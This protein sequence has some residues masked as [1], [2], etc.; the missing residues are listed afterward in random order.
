MSI[1]TNKYAQVD[2]KKIIVNREDRQRKLIDVED[3]VPSI[4]ERGVLIPIIINDDF[5]LIAGERR[6]TATLQLGL[7]TIPVRFAKDL[8][9]RDRQIIELE[10]N[11][12][13]QNLTWQ[14]T[15]EAVAK[16]HNLLVSEASDK[17]EPISW[18]MEQTAD[19]VGISRPSVSRYVKLQSD[20]EDGVPGV[21]KATKI[22]EAETASKRF[23]SRQVESA[24]SQIFSTP[25]ATKTEDKP[26]VQSNFSIQHADVIQWLDSYSGPQFNFI[27]MDLPYGVKLSSQ[28]G[29]QTHAETYDGDAPFE[30]LLDALALHWN[31]IAAPECHVMFWFSMKHYQK[32]LDWLT[33]LGL[34][35]DYNPGIWGKGNVGIIRDHEHFPRN[36]YEP[37]FLAYQG[38]RA[39]VKN[40]NNLINLTP[41][42]DFREEAIHMSEKPRP[43]L[44]HFFQMFV[45][46]FTRVFDP[47]CGSGS[48]IRAVA[49]MAPGASGLGLEISEESAKNAANKLNNEVGLRKLSGK[50]S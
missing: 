15:A 42:T 47:T 2:P 28:A 13:R 7:P 29:G 10:E 11:V 31:K 20:I 14:E 25:T 34:T 18:S 44:L 27:H 40:T 43:V 3:L 41:T 1:L 50:L 12:K 24:V 46:Q 37:V 45:D 4:R 21:A 22:S 17:P 30:A 49:E 36:V 5:S 33:S 35:V 26:D 9:E 38:N 23:H 48:A 32:C 6:L 16:I 19:H 8:S 39:L